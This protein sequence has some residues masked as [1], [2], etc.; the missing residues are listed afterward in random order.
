MKK[1][2]LFLILIICFNSGK[3]QSY[4]IKNGDTLGIIISVQQAQKLDKD[5]D[6]LNLLKQYKTEHDS[7]DSAYLVVIDNYGKE[8]VELKFKISTLEDINNNKDNMISNL[9]SQIEQYK[10]DVLLG[11][12][13]SAK[14]DTIITNYRTENI[15]LKFQRTIAFGVGGVLTLLGIILLIL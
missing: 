2:I 3:S 15:K 9:K 7:L 6:L 14:K 4:Y 10:R 8:V 1:I 5:Y 12:S 13:Q 11:D